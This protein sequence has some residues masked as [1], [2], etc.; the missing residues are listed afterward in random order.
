MAEGALEDQEPFNCPICLDP[1]KDPV[2]IPCGHNYCMACIEDYWSQNERTET[3]RCPECRESFTTRP[4]LNKNTMFAEVVERFKKASLRD[5]SPANYG[6][7][8]CSLCTGQ[9]VQA[10]RLCS[11]CEE[12][13][14]EAH[15][16]RYNNMNLREKRTVIVVGGEPP[17]NICLQHNMPLEIYCRTDQQLICSLCLMEHHRGHDAISVGP[18]STERQGTGDSRENKQQRRHRNR[19]RSH[20]HGRRKRKHSR[21]ASGHGNRHRK[22]LHSKRRSHHE[23][24]GRALT[25]HEHAEGGGHMVDRNRSGLSCREF[26]VLGKL[27]G[28]GMERAEEALVL[29]LNLVAAPLALGHAVPSHIHQRRSHLQLSS[30]QGCIGFHLKRGEGVGPDENEEDE[31]KGKG[32]IYSSDVTRNW[33]NF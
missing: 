12:P 7:R 22:S 27:L 13:C 30:S 18:K 24:L 32:G 16:A 2:T 6:P 5:S 26:P 23:G 28:C 29:Q 11:Q 17:K 33:S 31:A 20:E 21:H 19:H 25:R 4:V 9:K 14:C 1:L 8:K 10:V 15:T 3:Y